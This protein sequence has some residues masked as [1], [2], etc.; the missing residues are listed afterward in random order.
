MDPRDELDSLAGGVDCAACGEVV[1]TD[2][3]RVLAKRDDISFVEIQCG[4]CRSESLGI[5]IAT[6]RPAESDGAAVPAPS[7]GEFGPEDAAR[8]RDA[9]PIGSADLERVHDILTWGGLEALVDRRGPLDPP[10][11]TS[12]P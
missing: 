10:M 4:A 3:V 12:A 5:V 6:D 2:R 7:Y 11:G 1:P 9:R 8:F